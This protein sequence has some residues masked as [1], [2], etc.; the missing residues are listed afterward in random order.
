MKKPASPEPGTPMFPMFVDLRGKRILIAGGGGVALRKA[1][2]LAEC[3]AVL[4]VVAPEIRPEFE[5]LV[6]SGGGELRRRAYRAE[7]LEDV[8]MAIAATDDRAVNA[9]VARDAGAGAE[10]IPV[11]VADAPG[12]CSFFFPSFVEHDGYVAGISSSGRSP[13]RCRRLADT[14]RACWKDWVENVETDDGKK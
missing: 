6:R 4:R 2:V 9:Q 11:N 3:G 7:D 1:S 8:R 5:P 12:E 14:L 10:K 13:A